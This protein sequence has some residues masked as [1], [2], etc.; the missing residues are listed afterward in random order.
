MKFTIVKKSNHSGFNSFEKLWFTQVNSAC[1]EIHH[2][3]CH[4]LIFFVK[5][6]VFKTLSGISSKCQIIL[7]QIRSNDSASLIW[8]QAV[9]KGYQKTR[10]KVKEVMYSKTCLKLPFKKRQNKDVNA[11]WFLNEGQKYCRMLPLEH[12]AILLTCMKQ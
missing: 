12:S 8:V 9:L 7:I 10:Q 6:N 4:L 3:F 1:R 11:K 5:I 2:A